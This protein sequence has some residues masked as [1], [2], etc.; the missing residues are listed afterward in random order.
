M[1]IDFTLDQGIAIV[2]INRPERLNAMDGEHYRALNACWARVR[3]DNDIRV[4]V[5]TGQGEKSFSVGADLKSFV[6]HPAALSEFMLTQKDQLLNRGLEVWKPVIAAVNGFC[7]G[8]GMTLLLATDIRYAVPHA[9]FGLTEVKR[10]LFPANGGTQRVLQQLPYP[11]AMEMLLGGDSVDAEFAAKWGLINRIVPPDALMDTALETARRIAANGPLGV[12][13][14]K[15]LAVR[16]RDLDLV[17]GLRLEA[18]MLR[19]LQTS[20]DVQEGTKAFTEKR[21]PNFEGR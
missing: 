11:I 21:T 5:V 14:A 18:T 19:L 6:G 7:L 1:S 17:S 8:G 9:T 2:T 4:A 16:S 15:E 3:D 12:Q 20:E 10:G 13:A